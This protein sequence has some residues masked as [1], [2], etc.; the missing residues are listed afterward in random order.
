VN[1]FKNVKVYKKDIALIAGMHNNKK[2]SKGVLDK[3][4]A[5]IIITDFLS[6]IEKKELDDDAA[7]EKRKQL[8]HDKQY[9]RDLKKKKRA[10]IV[11]CITRFNLEIR[12]YTPD[13]IEDFIDE[14]VG[15]TAGYSVLEDAFND[16]AV[17]DI[18]CL[19]WNKIFVEKDGENV[20]YHK[21]FRDNHHYKVVVE[22]FMSEAGKELNIGENKIVN[23]ELFGDRGCATSEAISPDAISLTL[24]KHKEDHILYDEIIEQEVMSEEIGD[25]LKMAVDGEMNLICG[26]LTGS[27]KTTTIRAIIDEVVSKN[28]KRMLVCEDTQELFPKNEHTLQLVS[29]P[30]RNP[31]TSITLLD[32]IYTALRLKPKYVVVGEVRGQEAVAAVEAAETGHSTIFTMHGGKAENII[33]RLNSKYLMGMPSIG[34]E[35]ADRIIG[36]AIDFIFIQSHVPQYGRIISSVVEI[37]YN[38][39]QKGIVLRP[40]FRYDYDLKE[41]VLLARLSDEKIDKLIERGI[42]PKVARKWKHSDNEEEEKLF[43]KTVNENYRAERAQ[44]R[45]KYKKQKEER[46]AKRVQYYKEKLDLN[47]DIPLESL[48]LIEKQN[49]FEELERKTKQ[50]KEVSSD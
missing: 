33:N 31:D 4:D 12:G 42:D 14:M 11:D 27:G 49:E 50:L 1:N 21:T 17:S 25:F 26:G 24:R 36:A 34:S 23:F 40:I 39:S 16:P 6:E 44:R 43:I 29:S 41:H 15:E 38:F 46:I 28:K 10:Q 2:L 32:L 35:V 9:L 22:R 19:A 30:T 13:T 45:D 47:E 18:Y 7:M 3:E 48:E 37:S 5:Q 20:P 8:T